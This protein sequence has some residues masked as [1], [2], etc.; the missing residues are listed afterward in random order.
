MHVRLNFLLA[1][2][3]RTVDVFNPQEHSVRRVNQFRPHRPGRVCRLLKIAGIW[4]NSIAAIFGRDPRIGWD[5][6]IRLKIAM[7]WA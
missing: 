6:G 4:N 7:L 2:T 5:F 3:I 1:Q